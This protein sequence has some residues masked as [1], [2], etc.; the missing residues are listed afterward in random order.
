MFLTQSRS[1]HNQQHNSKGHHP[2]DHHHHHHHKGSNKRHSSK[3]D[4]S[5]SRFQFW[6]WIVCGVLCSCMSIDYSIR[7]FFHKHHVASAATNAPT[8]LSN[9][10]NNNEPVDILTPL[11]PLQGAATFSPGP[12]SLNLQPETTGGYRFDSLANVRPN[13]NQHAILIPYRD[14]QFHLSLFLEYMGP[15]LQHH[16]P[17]AEFT[18][19]VIE[20]DDAE[21]FNRAWLANV[22]LREI[23]SQAPNTSCVIFH[24]VDLVPNMTS[25]VPYTTCQFPTQLGSELQHFNWT[26][27]YPAYCG[28]I[29]SLSLKH[30]QLINGLGNGTLNCIVFCCCLRG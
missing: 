23:V 26:V 25:H 12:K 15:Y 2:G 29:T 1:R 4:S 28:G 8:T 11:R 6:S 24:D 9:N 30:W 13:P 20:Q 27:P 21:L 22:G 16:F 14:R 7:A 10:N 18:L 17:H 19:W 5:T 3:H